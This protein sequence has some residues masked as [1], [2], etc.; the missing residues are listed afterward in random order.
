VNLRQPKSVQ[1][2]QVS[3]DRAQVA[4]EPPEVEGEAR[5]AM[6]PGPVNLIDDVGSGAAVHRVAFGAG[7]DLVVAVVAGKIVVA[8]KSKERVVARVAG[9]L[10]V[11]AVAGD[12][13][14]ALTPGDGIV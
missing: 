8:G 1:V 3:D 4:D 6:M 2:S 10:V 12:E 13:V 11:A 9:E 14:I 7:D 5:A